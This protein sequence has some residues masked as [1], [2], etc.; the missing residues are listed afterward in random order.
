VNEIGWTPKL[1]ADK[2]EG[3]YAIGSYVWGLPNYSYTPTSYTVT[4]FNPA[5][6]KYG[7]GTSVTKKPYPTSY[8]GAAW[9]IYLQADQMLFR[10]HE[11]PSGGLARDAGSSGGKNPAVPSKV[12]SERGLLSFNE[13]SFTPPQNNAMPFYFQTGLVYKGLLDARPMDQIGIVCGMG[14]YSSYLNSWTQ[15]QN[16]ALVN[17]Y[18]SAV[19]AT[20]PNGPSNVNPVTGKTTSD[21]GWYPASQPNYTTTEV[22]E[23]FYNVQLNKWASFKPYAQCLINPAGNGTLPTVWTLGA[24]LAVVF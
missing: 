24:R 12:L 15:S 5:T 10:H 19:N 14:F 1:T 17:A 8:N 3:R 4:V 18:G 16:Q 2:L 6:G 9:G 13:F 22:I 23:G 21:T 20:V 7:T 11:K